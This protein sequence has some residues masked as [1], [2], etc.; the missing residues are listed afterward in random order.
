LYFTELTPWV[1]VDPIYL[2]IG[3]LF[4]FVVVEVCNL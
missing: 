2:Q 1:T 3:L 4:H